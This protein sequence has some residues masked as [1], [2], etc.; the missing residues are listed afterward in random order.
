MSV[1]IP[2]RSAT[3]TCPVLRRTP[4][5]RHLCVAA[6]HAAPAPSTSAGSASRPVTIVS[7][8]PP[9]PSSRSTTPVA[10]ASVRSSVIRVKSPSTTPS[11]S[12]IRQRPA[13]VQASF[14][15]IV[16]APCRVCPAAAESWTTSSSKL[17]SGSWT[18][19][20][21][22][23]WTCARVGITATRTPSWRAAVAA[24]SAT[25]MESLSFGSSTISAPATA[26]SPSAAHRS[27]SVGPGRPG[28]PPWRRLRRTG[29]ASPSPAATAITAR[30]GTG[31][32]VRPGRRSG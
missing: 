14:T 5:H 6:A 28:R 4:R 20:A 24:A 12:P 1:F 31:A 3:G 10:A 21:A 25:A 26:R 23:P 17:R 18:A 27:S 32:S 22:S 15:A 8:S 19:I 30:S 7:S 2:P 29:S 13:I 16:T 11:A 9:P